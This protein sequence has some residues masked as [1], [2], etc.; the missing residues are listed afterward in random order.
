M[1]VL[2]ILPS[3]QYSGSAKQLL[4]LA[5]NLPPEEV[6]QRVC[7]LGSPGPMLPAIHGAGIAVDA[8]NWTRPINPLPLWRLRR[9]IRSWQP[10]VIHAWR[11]PAV[12]ALTLTSR[13]LPCNWLAHE[14]WNGQGL[15]RLDAWLLRRAPRVVV[16][17][18]SHAD[19][20][21]AAG[22]PHEKTIVINPGV[23]HSANDLPN[24]ARQVVCAGTLE[25]HKGYFDA[26]WVADILKHIFD[27]VRL[28]VIGDGPDR[29]RLDNFVNAIRAS[30]YV[31]L[32][33]SDANV[34][35]HLSRAGAVWIPS[36][37]ESGV[38]VAL[39]AM[40]LGKPVISSAVGTL[41]EIIRDGETGFLVPPGD[42]IAL[43]RD[44]RLLFDDPDLRKRVA[45]AGQDHVRTHFSAVKMS[46]CF[47]QLYQDLAA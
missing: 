4:L 16:R 3:L 42:K 19:E 26:I 34:Q 38:N 5:K 23:E 10:D 18:S 7:V 29:G 39:E 6:E 37:R 25:R 24:M 32:H 1:R 2:H 9:L 12:R 14:V 17:C 27:D 20:L 47:S 41:R 13:R 43:A 35:A 30:D 33:A 22:L 44:T 45:L 21:R 8:L 36:L 11:L 31:G 46:Q 28:D 40:S 15:G